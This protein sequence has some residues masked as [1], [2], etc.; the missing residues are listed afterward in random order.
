MVVVAADEVSVSNEVTMVVVTAPAAPLTAM[1][2]LHN[3][4]IASFLA[5]DAPASRTHVLTVPEAEAVQLTVPPHLASSHEHW[6]SP[7]AP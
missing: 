1:L 2:E 6:T 7:S 5:T 4:P 3:T